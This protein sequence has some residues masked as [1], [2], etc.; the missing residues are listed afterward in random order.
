ME[1]TKG[2]IMS[3]LTDAYQRRDTVGMVVFHKDRA[4]EVLPPT[5]SVE[6]AQRLL[7]NLPVGGKT[8]LAAGLWLSLQIVQH[9][10]RRSPEVVP[11]M[12]ILTDGAGNVSLGELPAQEEAYRIA[13][14]IREAKIRAVVIN[15]ETAAFDQGLAQSLAEHLDGPCYSLAGLQADTLLRTVQEE[16]AGR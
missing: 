3:L 6:L 7:A 9:E 2:A 1:A 4:L 15:M 11:L 13:A 16:L 14:Q 10:R 8:P 5:N 12:V